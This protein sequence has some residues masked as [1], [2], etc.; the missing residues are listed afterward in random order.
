MSGAAR[1]AIA[2]LDRQVKERGQTVRL[3]RAG[4]RDEA[5]FR[6][7]RCVVRGYTPTE[8]TGGI[9]Q[10]DSKVVISP[11]ALAEA[12]IEP[13]SELDFLHI[14]GTRR[15]VKFCNPVKMNDIVVRYDA[16]VKGPN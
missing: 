2:T 12:G 13:P 11:T 3:Q 15:S 4:V 10:G 8:L 9:D 6:D 14:D 7:F 5:T 16:W 1:R